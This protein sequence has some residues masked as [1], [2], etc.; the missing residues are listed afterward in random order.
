MD[1]DVQFNGGTFGDG[2]ATGECLYFGGNIT[3]SGGNSIE[4]N[5]GTMIMNGTNLIQNTASI[6]LNGGSFHT[7]IGT[8][9]NT[10]A[11]NLTLSADSSI[12]VGKDNAHTLTFTGTADLSTFT[13]TIYD[14]QGTSGAGGASSAGAIIMPGLSGTEL[15]NINFYGWVPGA[16]YIGGN[17]IAPASGTWDGTS[18]HA[19][20]VPLVPEASTWWGGFSLLSFALWH[21]SWRRRK[22]IRDH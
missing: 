8:G 19:C 18:L 13:L 7:G 15:D 22:R 12:G 6:N 1:V 3:V 4:I 10:T 20:N 21:S 11:T 5:G 17:E 9:Y 16:V 14:W 2:D